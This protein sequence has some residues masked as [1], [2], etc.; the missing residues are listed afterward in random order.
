MPEQ[1]PFTFCEFNNVKSLDFPLFPR[2]T[3]FTD[4]RVLTA[5]TMDALLSGST[6]AEEYQYY[7]VVMPFSK[8]YRK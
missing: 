2:R 1:K 5:A 7:G 3:C 4:D 6:Y 8:K